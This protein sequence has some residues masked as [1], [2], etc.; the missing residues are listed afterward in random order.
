MTQSTISNTNR[1]KINKACKAL[2]TSQMGTEL[3]TAQTN[4]ATAETNITALQAVAPTANEKAG[5]A[6]NTPSAANPAQTLAQ[7]T[8]HIASATANDTGGAGT[9]TTCISGIELLYSET[10]VD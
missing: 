5:L 10:L 1:D 9:A 6:A 4:L 8:T 7:M 2:G 3:Q